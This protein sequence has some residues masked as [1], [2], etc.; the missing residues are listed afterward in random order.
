MN[1]WIVYL[2][3]YLLNYYFLI[4][5]VIG[6]KSFDSS[7]STEGAKGLFD[8][9]TFNFPSLSLKMK[10]LFIGAASFSSGPC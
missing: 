3:T 4:I 1:L 2:M 6:T 8:L 9:E 10:L 5:L 7:I